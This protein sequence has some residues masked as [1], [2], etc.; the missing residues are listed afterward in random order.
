MN[1]LF[2]HFSTFRWVLLLIFLSYAPFVMYAQDDPIEQEPAEDDWTLPD[3]VT[4]S[5]NSGIIFYDFQYENY[6]PQYTDI[7]TMGYKWKDLNP[8]E[9]VYNWNL[10]QDDL[11]EYENIYLRIG[12]SD[13][14]HVPQWVFDKYPGL[15]E[16]AFFVSEYTDIFN[17]QSDGYFIP[18]WHEGV[19]N[20]LNQ[21]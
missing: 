13:T 17:V 19:K 8:E 20:E 1:R 14:I 4:R 18:F 2:K 15:K 3:W 12:L 10:I 9:G 5:F 7:A 21:F 6:P 11:D 16:S